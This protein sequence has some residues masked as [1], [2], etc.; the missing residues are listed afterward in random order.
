[1]DASLT[2]Q[3]APLRISV[4]SPFP[5]QRPYRSCHALIISRR[6]SLRRTPQ[7]HL[8]V[9]RAKSAGTSKSNSNRQPSPLHRAASSSF[10][11]LADF[12]RGKFRAKFG[13]FR[14]IVR[15]TYQS[16]GKSSTIKAVAD[17]KSKPPG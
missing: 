6:N 2:S 4:G 10:C 9:V 16:L 13:P 3:V 15:F 1:M 14:G 5:K 8:G 17:S 7:R 12:R 11:A